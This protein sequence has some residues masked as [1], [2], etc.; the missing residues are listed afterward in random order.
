MILESVFYFIT[1]ENI[2]L[3]IDVFPHSDY[4]SILA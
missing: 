1:T 2:G 3:V 4:N